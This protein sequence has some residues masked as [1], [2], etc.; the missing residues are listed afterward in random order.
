V[1]VRVSADLGI[2]TCKRTLARLNINDSK[3]L[4]LMEDYAAY[5]E[6]PEPLSFGPHFGEEAADEF[7]RRLK[8]TGLEYAEDFFLFS[9][10]VPEWCGVSCFV[11]QEV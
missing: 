9:G 7:I 6:D 1:S 10:D 2:V 4:S 8:K 11:A 3:L 5:D